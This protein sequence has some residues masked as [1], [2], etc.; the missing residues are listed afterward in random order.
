MKRLDTPARASF[1][2]E[3][4]F[5]SIPFYISSNIKKL[6]LLFGIDSLKH[7]FDGRKTHSET[8][9]SPYLLATDHNLDARLVEALT[10]H[11]D[12]PL[13]SPLTTPPSTPPPTPL[14]SPISSP[15]SSTVSLPI[16]QPLTANLPTP[17]EPSGLDNEPHRKN[18]PRNKKKSH[19][20]RKRRRQMSNVLVFARNP[21]RIKMHKL[22]L[23]IVSQASPLPETVQDEHLKPTSTSYLGTQ[24]PLPDK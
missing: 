1:C 16:S 19:E 11:E 6:R 3:L 8:Y 18:T 23:A 22:R 12:F 7:L 9:F 24:R 10:A 4:H 15:R 13:E 5:I 20:L 21:T 14:S 2:G 17:S